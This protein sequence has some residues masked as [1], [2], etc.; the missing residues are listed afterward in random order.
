MKVWHSYGSEHSAA[1]VMIGRFKSEQD[2][3]IFL[4]ELRKLQ[5]TIT[6]VMPDYEEQGRFPKEIM[7]NLYHGKIR[8]CYDM[9]PKDLDDFLLDYSIDK[10]E[11]NGSVVRMT[12]DDVGWA[13]LIKMMINAGARVEI[14]SEHNEKKKDA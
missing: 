2:A 12:T 13:G 7:D 4:A 3:N 9:S 10:D 5:E 1:L 14:F 6:A 11:Q 8:F